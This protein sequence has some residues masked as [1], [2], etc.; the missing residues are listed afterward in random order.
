MR[1]IKEHPR[2]RSSAAPVALS[3]LKGHYHA[4]VP[5]VN[6]NAKT[7]EGLSQIAKRKRSCD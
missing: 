2:R 5:E 7:I 6:P 4:S 1:I 3:I